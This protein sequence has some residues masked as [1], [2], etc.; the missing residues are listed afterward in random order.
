MKL[1]KMKIIQMENLKL[2]SPT[3]NQ[4]LT[5]QD[6]I[7]NAENLIQNIDFAFLCSL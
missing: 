7:L 2:K 4:F 5:L 3:S 6:V 1:Q